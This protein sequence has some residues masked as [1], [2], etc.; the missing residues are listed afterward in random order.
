MLE[1]ILYFTFIKLPAA[2][3]LSGVTLVIFSY[4]VS[5]LL[6]PLVYWIDPE[7]FHSGFYC[8]FGVLDD[9]LVCNGWAVESFGETFLAFLVFIPTLPLTC[10]LNNFSAK[11][12]CRVTLNFLSIDNNTNPS[13]NKQ[14]QQ[15][16]QQQ[17]QTNA[18]SNNNVNMTYINS[19]NNTNIMHPNSYR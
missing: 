9:N 19:S 12:L 4:V 1:V 13:Q 10:L 2:F 8:L 16:Q 5:I 15:Q 18:T 17:Q 14:Q 7:Y 11:L 3:I 6:S